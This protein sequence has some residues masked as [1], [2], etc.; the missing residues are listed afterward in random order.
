MCHKK[1]YASYNHAKADAKAMRRKTH[2]AYSVYRCNACQGW[3]VGSIDSETRL[4][5]RRALAWA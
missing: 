1:P 4:R 3:H 5:H 2:V